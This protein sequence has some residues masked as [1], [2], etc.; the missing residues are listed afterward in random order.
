MT[1][2]LLNFYIKAGFI[3]GKRSGIENLSVSYNEIIFI[4]RYRM[5]RLPSI[6]NINSKKLILNCVVYTGS[7]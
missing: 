4:S 2:G 3:F 6:G 1:K 5:G 7:R